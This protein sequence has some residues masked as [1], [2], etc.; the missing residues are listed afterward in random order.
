MA[1]GITRHG[2][3][4][5]PP[6]KARL[7][8]F[9]ASPH[10]NRMPKTCGL[11]LAGPMPGQP[12]ASELSQA[13]K[14]GPSQSPAHTVVSVERGGHARRDRIHRSSAQIC[15]RGMPDQWR[16][17]NLRPTGRLRTRWRLRTRRGDRLPLEHL[18][19]SRQPHAQ[20]RGA[21]KL[22]EHLIFCDGPGFCDAAAAARERARM[23]RFSGVGFLL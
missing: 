10:E 14:H 15:P 5:Q 21:K 4:M 6:R 11:A 2:D 23:D 3:Q 9:A 8:M 16:R 22:A 1:I 20:D 17:C 18:E 19:C 7:L 13:S 12:C